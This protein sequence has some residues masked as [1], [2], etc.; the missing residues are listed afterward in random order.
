MPADA[1]PPPHA[2]FVWIED[3]AP[4][5]NQFVR[6]EQRFGLAEVPAEFFLHLFADTR[7]RLRVNG[8]FVAAGPGRFVTQ[9]P[10][11]DTHDIAPLLAAGENKVAVEVNFFGASSYQSMPDGRPG[12]MAWGGNAG[13]DLATP[14]SWE[15]LRMEAWCWDAPLFSFAQNPVEIC[16]TRL[17]PGGVPREPVILEGE[18]APWPIPTPYSGV[19]VPFTKHRPRQIELAGAL[20]GGERRVGFMAQDPA[21]T[22]PGENGRTKP[23]I[24]FATWIHSPR[25]QPARL[26]CFWSELVCNGEPVAVDTDTVYGN[27]GHCTLPLQE[28]WNLLTGNVEVLTEFWAYCLGIPEDLG[29]SLH[30]R[31]DVG[32]A[33]PFAVSPV[34]PRNELQV[35]PP[36]AVDPPPG[37]SLHDGDPMHLTPA[38]MMAWDEPATDALRN[39]AFPRLAE[40]SSITAAAAT[41]CLSFEGEFLGHI[42]LEVDAPAGTILDVATDDWQAGHGGV[43]LYQSNPFTDAADRFIL[44]GGRQRIELFHPRGGKLLQATL[45]APGGAVELSLQDVF[46]RSRQ[47]FG[48]EATR[49]SCDH[50]ELEWAWPVALR[51][52]QVSTDESYSDC[53]WRERGSYIGDSYVNLHLHLLM[54]NDYRTARRTLRLFGQA[55]LPDGQLACCAPSWLRKPH[56]DFTLIWI[57]AVHDFWAAT[58]DESFIREMWPTIEGIWAS[59]S[60]KVGTG[61]LWDTTGQRV[62]LDWGVLPSER[63]GDTNAAV[64]LFRLGA[65]RASAALAKAI[66]RPPEAAKFLAE[67]ESVQGAL[68]GHLWHDAEGRLRASAEAGT[69]AL[70]ANVLALAFAAGDSARRESIL[71]YLEPLLRANFSRGIRDGQFSGHLELYFFHY[72]LPALAEHGRPDL[73][74]MLIRQHYGFLQSIGDD[75]LPECFC[76]VERSVGSRCHSWSGAPAIYATR[77]VLGIRR[78]IA[79]DFRH[80]VCDPI[81]HGITRASGRIAHPNG[82]IE[83]EWEKSRN[84]INAR[85]DAPHGV[86]VEIPRACSSY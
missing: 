21:G 59:S 73:A 50:A 7:Y 27:H 35:L 58:G 15:A 67:A 57:L 86:T 72:A 80:L 51:T 85:V 26:S 64:N 6:F 46:V 33:A 24:A 78:R 41:W 71:S 76:R 30:G 5:R 20:A 42:V 43:A 16:D 55:A 45:R 29:L 60:W 68:F 9:F 48:P 62:F 44:R 10:E 47:T 37:W 32:C 69:P 82:W 52:L 83:V 31:R 61:G 77:Y 81:V 75:T 84:G 36:E 74:E 18:A 34:L 70:H 11:F 66:G 3:D 22:R 56:E 49:F 8:E 40:V 12:F 53:P 38:R 39:L 1:S 13:V 23:W 63:E 14:G 65:L 2:R 19:P 28:G 4:R 54:S 17:L 79:G 25:T